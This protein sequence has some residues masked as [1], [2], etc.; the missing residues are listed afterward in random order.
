MIDSIKSVAEQF[1]KS[2]DYTDVFDNV[3]K[4]KKNTDL[5]KKE[6]YIMRR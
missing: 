1:N 4:Q 6:N 3:I 2:D 5:I